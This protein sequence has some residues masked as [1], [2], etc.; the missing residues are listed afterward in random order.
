MNAALLLSKRADTRELIRK[1][2]KELFT[3]ELSPLTSF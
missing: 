1:K 3:D 2:T